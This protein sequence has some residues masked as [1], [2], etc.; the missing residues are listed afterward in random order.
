MY[1]M[2]TNNRVPGKKSVNLGN[3]VRLPNVVKRL[4]A[5]ESKPAPDPEDS[6]DDSSGS[7]DIVEGTPVEAKFGPFDENYD[8]TSG[9]EG[10]GDVN[11]EEEEEEE[12]NEEE[13]EDGE[14][15]LILEEQSDEDQEEEEEPEQKVVKEV[16]KEYTP[17]TK[18]NPR[19]TVLKKT[20]TTTT[21]VQ[22]TP[23]R[24]PLGV[25]VSPPKIEIRKTVS[26]TPRFTPSVPTREDVVGDD[27]DSD[28]YLI[29]NKSRLKEKSPP[30]ITATPSAASR[31]SPIATG[32]SPPQQA[33]IWATPLPA[34]PQKGNTPAMAAMPALA[35]MPTL[36]ATYAAVKEAKDAFERRESSG[37][38]TSRSRGRA[39]DTPSKRQ[40]RD[41]DEEDEEEEEKIPSPGEQLRQKRIKHEKEKK[42]R[43]KE[44]KEQLLERIYNEEI[45]E[46][47][48]LLF[49]LYR[50]ETGK[51]PIALSK[52]FDIDDEL[53]E[54]RF[55]YKRAKND[56]DTLLA[57]N[58]KWNGLVLFNNLLELGNQV[59]NPAVSAKGWSEE[60]AKHR[61]EYE[62]YLAQ[63]SKKMIGW[64]RQYPNRMIATMMLTQLLTFMGPRLI[65]MVQ[66]FIEKK[67]NAKNPRKVTFDDGADVIRKEV[68]DRA[69][70][71]SDRRHSELV[72]QLEKDKS[73][74]HAM[75][76]A[77][78][79]I[80]AR[81]FSQNSQILSLL[82]P[83]PPSSAITP[84]SH[85]PA[86]SP[87]PFSFSV[88]VSVPS[89]SLPPQ[90]PIT[91]AMA[92]QQTAREP[93]PAVDPELEKQR[94]A[95]ITKALSA[96]TADR[97]T[98]SIVASM[99]DDDDD[100][101]MT[102]AQV[103]ALR[104]M[105]LVVPESTDI[106]PMLAGVLGS[107]SSM[108]SDSEERMDKATM[109]ERFSTTTGRVPSV[110]ELLSMET[111][112]EP[113][114]SS[115]QGRTKSGK[116]GGGMDV[117]DFM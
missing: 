55:E 15:Q 58:S 22:K 109:P 116:R 7:E 11:I 30:R 36:A 1:S 40:A 29:A 21:M 73:D 108:I 53:S 90:P 62:P 26:E 93:T 59:L 80:N 77:Q 117:S 114:P 27:D 104:N 35:A 96:S 60:L 56:K 12:D 84:L 87:S 48:I 106:V 98:G 18:K 112:Q 2:S 54:I 102:P 105:P 72:A 95:L 41:D 74:I 6:E 28:I 85:P 24:P 65:T 45:K 50:L 32:P 33:S 68:S 69:R 20:V 86:L 46:K 107:T 75:F 71:Q 3:G 25:R 99:A 94:Q 4:S 16:I 88:P 38:H 97:N 23:T 113:K 52:S 47:R 67:K 89:P 76:K 5:I 9:D 43:G 14:D 64:S 103:E 79:D 63:G 57:M 111:P 81:T 13:E 61:D 34:S 78:H 83:Q 66:G 49:E 51:P 92:A 101:D 42:Q 110:E 37:S 17:A 31:P 39:A 100:D 115:N 70:E 10:E 19:G 8:F 91:P 82:T 44:A